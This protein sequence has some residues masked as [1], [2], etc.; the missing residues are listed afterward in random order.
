V[1]GETATG[2][3]LILLA[4][5]GAIRFLNRAQTLRSRGDWDGFR[6]DCHRAQ[7]II[8]ELAGAL[9]LAHGGE[10]ASNL[11]A[12]YGYLNQRILEADYKRDDHAIPEVLNLLRDLRSAWEEAVRQ[13]GSRV[14]TTDARAVAVS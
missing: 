2:G 14:S 5:N 7:D 13:T 3:Q 1:Q 12:L 8:T 11:F 10:F 4:Y 9:D 6:A